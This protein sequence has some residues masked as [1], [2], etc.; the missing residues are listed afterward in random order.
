L[1]ATVQRLQALEQQLTE[2]VCE[3][4]GPQLQIAEQRFQE[5]KQELRAA[6]DRI[7]I[8]TERHKAVEQSLR[9]TEPK[10][11]IAEQSCQR[12]DEWRQNAEQRFK[13]NDEQLQA[14]VQRLEG[15]ECQ[16]IEAVGQINIFE[17]KIKSCEE[18]L[19][20]DTGLP[21]ETKKTFDQQ[22]KRLE[23]VEISIGALTQQIERL[24][25]PLSKAR[26]KG[27]QALLTSNRRMQWFAMIAWIMSLLLVGYAG[28]GT[29]GFSVV[30][31]YLSHWGLLI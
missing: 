17:P 14:T 28:T 5:I 6:E 15:L 7:E 25:A 18:S 26:L 21:V 11:A 16:L 9:A 20:R 8:A 1:L 10:I 22:T 31:Q 4:F 30:R 3:T 19:Q 13:D 12:I 29:P 23:N 24:K 2:A 27:L